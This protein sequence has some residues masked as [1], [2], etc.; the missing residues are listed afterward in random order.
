MNT[1]VSN[2]VWS[3][4]QAQRT[5]T[6]TKVATTIA[7]LAG[8]SV[9]VTG[10]S[11]REGSYLVFTQYVGIPAPALSG[12]FVAIA[13]NSG[14]TVNFQVIEGTFF[15]LAASDD[16]HLMVTD[17]V[18]NIPS[19]DIF[20]G[21]MSAGAGAKLNSHGS[22]AVSV[23]T[24][25]GGQTG[26]AIPVGALLVFVGVD[27]AGLI[28]KFYIA[29][30]LTATTYRVLTGTEYTGSLASLGDS[31]LFVL[32]NPR[33]CVCNL[34][35]LKVVGIEKIEDSENGMWIPFKSA[36]Q[37]EMLGQNT[38]YDGNMVYYQ[39]DPGTL[40]VYRGITSTQGMFIRVPRIHYWTELQQ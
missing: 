9:T 8:N 1:K 22:G 37:F 11:I 6:Y 38:V 16:V 28:N 31:R 5:E 2:F 24:T 3:I 20:T 25:F 33:Y 12:Q 39:E 17:A 15:T 26:Y 4:G 32:E 21:G 30:A 23:A 13:T 36:A 27:L 35:S 10:V 18:F 14:L 7:A 29:E 34:E 19:T 40:K